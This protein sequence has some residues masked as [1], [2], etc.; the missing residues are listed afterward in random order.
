MDCECGAHS[1]DATFYW[2]LI[3]NRSYVTNGM[4]CTLESYCHKWVSGPNHTWLQ[5]C[6]TN[7]LSMLYQWHCRSFMGVFFQVFVHYS[8][9]WCRKITLN[10]FVIWTI[11]FCNSN[12]CPLQ[13]CHF[14]WREGWVLKSTCCRRQYWSVF[15]IWILIAC[16]TSR[17]SISMNLQLDSIQRGINRC[18]SLPN[19]LFIWSGNFSDIR[20]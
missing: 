18:S 20:A 17:R 5:Q 2:I 7:R 11:F 19:D 12:G 1:D 13:R 9:H 3:E 6:H 4:F 8:L 15:V 16:T 10:A 14:G